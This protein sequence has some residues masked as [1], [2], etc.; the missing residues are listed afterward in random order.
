MDISGFGST[1]I[2]WSNNATALYVNREISEDTSYDC[3]TVFGLQGDIKL[4]DDLNQSVQVVNRPQD[5][6]SSPELEWAYLGYSFSD[7]NL[8]AGRLRLPLFLDAE[9][10]YVG[11]A[12]ETDAQLFTLM[13]SFIF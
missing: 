6:W 11:Q 9:Y 5:D 1:S 7:Y 2:A 12:D 4:T 13:L 3:D 10:Y 8:R